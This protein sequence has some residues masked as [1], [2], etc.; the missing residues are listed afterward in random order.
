MAFLY[1][2]SL[3]AILFY[4]IFLMRSLE[5]Y[6]SVRC[7][8]MCTPFVLYI[9]Y[10]DLKPVRLMFSACKDCE[11]SGN[12]L[13]GK[14][15]KKKLQTSKYH[16]VKFPSFKGKL[17]SSFC[18]L[19]FTHHCFQTWKHIFSFITSKAYFRQ[20]ILSLLEP[21]L[22]SQPFSENSVGN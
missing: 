17:P 10:I 5:H 20:T 11:D 22:H 2:N 4:F 15:K 12:F 18:L 14:Q 16:Q 19:L 21:N 6:I 9:H 3:I 13:K 8:H 7:M 1:H